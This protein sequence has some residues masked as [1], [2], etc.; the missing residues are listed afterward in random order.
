MS[1]K[2]YISLSFD[3]GRVDNYINVL[4]ILEKYRLKATIHIISGYIDGTYHNKL[5]SSPGP[6]SINQLLEM[7]EK[8]FEISL[9][10]DMHITEK[11]DYNTC[12]KKLKEWK[13]IENKYGFSIPHSDETKLTNDFIKNLKTTE[14]KYIRTGKNLKKINIKYKLLYLLSVA[15]SSKYF[16]NL[17]NDINVNKINEINSML[18]HSIVVK[19]NTKWKMIKNLIDKRKNKSEWIILMFHSV[20]EE[21]DPLYN[22]SDWAWSIENFERLCEYLFKLQNRNEIVVDTIINI[23]KKGDNN[24]L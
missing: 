22:E 5:A 12:V 6:C 4:P 17:Y 18:L 3:D 7:K 16:F 19:K 14:T 15:F 10:G 24:E 13:L 8:G 20:L 21:K 11:D 9:H 2:L 23:V 1:K